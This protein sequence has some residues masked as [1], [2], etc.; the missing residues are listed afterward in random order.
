MIARIM[1]I[2]EAG[3]Y[4][5]VAQML[6]P[7]PDD[8]LLDIGCGPGA[9][10]AIKAQDA[11]RVVGL[12][13]SPLMLRVAEKRLA[14]RIAAGT[15][16]L[17]LGSAAELPFGDGEF[18]TV[19]AIFAPVNH[20]EVFRVLRPDGRFVGADNDPRKSASEPSSR[21]GRQRWDEADHRQM[22]EDAGFTDLT[23]RYEGDYLLGSGRRPAVARATAA[24]GTGDRQ[25]STGHSPRAMPK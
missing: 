9:F 13:A 8:E 18:S 5:V 3:V 23:V 17:V 24:V 10:L 6:D 11:R 14:D 19:T 20:A 15:A 16:R 2:I 7:Q 4:E 22:L 25:I 12:D 1:P 21:W